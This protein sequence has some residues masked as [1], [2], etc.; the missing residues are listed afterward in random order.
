[1]S[2]P[3]EPRIVPRP[4][5]R[6]S[7]LRFFWSPPLSDGDGSGISSYTFNCL[8]PS[9][10]TTSFPAYINREDI[11]GLSNGVPYVFDL[12]ATNSN[13]ISSPA[14]T[15]NSRIPCTFP[16]NPTNVSIAQNRS[17][18][19]ILV[20]WSTPTNTG[21]GATSLDHN[22]IYVYPVDNNSNI[23]S[24]ADSNLITRVYTYGSSNS[25]LV[26]YPSPNYNYKCIVRAINQAGWSGDD[27]N[28]Y[29]FINAKDLNPSEYGTLSLWLD[30]STADN[31]F[32]LSNGSTSNI[33]TINDKGYLGLKFNTKHLVNMPFLSTT[34]NN[35]TTITLF[36]SDNSFKQSTIISTIKHVFFVARQGLPPSDYNTIFG[37]PTLSSWTYASR[38]NY[39]NQKNANATL[40]ING[41]APYSSAW[42][43]NIPI[44][45]FRKPFILNINNIGFAPNLN[46]VGYGDAGTGNNVG[47]NGDLAEILC[48]SN[49]LTTSQI[50]TVNGYLINKWFPSPSNFSPSSLSGCLFWLDMSKPN[51]FTMSGSNV[52]TITDFS[53]WSNN[54]TLLPTNYTNPLFGSSIN[55]LSTIRVGSGRALRVNSTINGTRHLFWVGRQT[56]N[57]DFPFILGSDSDYAW[58][59]GQSGSTW[60][61]I[62]QYYADVYNGSGYIYGNDTAFAYANPVNNALNV[63]NCNSVFLLNI[64][65]VGTYNAPF[66]GI[67]Y[68]RNIWPRGWTGDLAEVICYNSTLTTQEIETVEAYLKN[69]WGIKPA[70]ISTPTQLSSLQLWLDATD[71]YGNGTIPAQSTPITTWTDKSG[72]SRNATAN[73]NNNFFL[74]TCISQRPSIRLL[75]GSYFTGTISPTYSRNTCYVFIVYAGESGSGQY[76]RIFAAGNS[77]QEDYA[78]DSYFG[79]LRYGA[80]AN[81][82]GI[83]R[84]NQVVNPSYAFQG[85]G[86]IPNGNLITVA[87]N[88]TTLAEC[89]VN[90]ISVSQGNTNT[91]AATLALSAYAIGTNVRT[92]YGGEG[93][94]EGYVSEVLM[95]STLTSDQIFSVEAY[96]KQKWNV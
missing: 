54:L 33:S 47:W 14:A 24:N 91:Y 50:S 37:A 8:S 76:G 9:S 22:A 75:N 52:S 72:L 17:T 26:Y 60:Q 46:G 86:S 28:L 81:N 10:I 68:D 23:L 45:P 79:I 13:G 95:Y 63:P 49:T 65:T 88:G 92:G 3:S 39:V 1:M 48:Y 55:G 70:P 11:T 56:S 67:T 35:K 12:Y 87:F 96:L 78:S 42:V 36:N 77:T 7:L 34:L 31:N 94:F 74:S 66:Q 71:P 40:F 80:G 27:P 16:G 18:N 69:K 85:S 19:S 51:G 93:F 25:R 61:F 21:G 84:N 20:T 57:A 38:N 6:D 30:L 59:P 32:N 41:T 82:L 89:R 2:A 29:F 62:T 90:G 43:Q 64:N 15:F 58:H 5:S 44:A 73:T 4:T 53:R 83:Y